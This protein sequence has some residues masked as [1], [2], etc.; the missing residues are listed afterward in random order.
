MFVTNCI[1]FSISKWKKRKIERGGGINTVWLRYIRFIN[2]SFED[3]FR[4]RFWKK[5][6][7]TERERA[8]ENNPDCFDA[9]IIASTSD[10]VKNRNGFFSYAHTTQPYGVYHGIC[11]H[12]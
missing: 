9:I 11:Y 10:E 2:G 1:A 6:S 7:K 3:R 5:G 8:K 4:I 12:V